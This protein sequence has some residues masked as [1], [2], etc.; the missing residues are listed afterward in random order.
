MVSSHHGIL[1]MHAI[2]GSDGTEIWSTGASDWWQ[3]GASD[4]AWPT[5]NAGGNDAIFGSSPSGTAGTVTVSGT[6][7]L[8]VLTF[9]APHA[10]TRRGR[11]YGMTWPTSHFLRYDL[12]KKEMKDLGPMYINGER[13]T[14]KES[15]GKGE[16]KGLEDLHLVTYDIPTARY[17]DHGAVFLPDGQ[18]PLYV[19]SIAVAKDGTVYTLGR[20][21]VGDHTRTDLIR[22]L[23]KSI[24]LSQ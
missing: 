22:I 10:G 20:I 19:N 1:G 11:L 4:T 2:N 23:A 8:N 12:A 24:V 16:A 9:N 21:T 18:R 7:N 13:M 17:I 14:G 15:T 6:N 5:T 3:N